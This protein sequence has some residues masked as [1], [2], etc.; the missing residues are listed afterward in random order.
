MAESLQKKVVTIK[1][2]YATHAAVIAEGKG[3]I[4]STDEYICEECSKN[5]SAEPHAKHLMKNGGAMIV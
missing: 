4:E 1:K 3:E 2:G 5:V